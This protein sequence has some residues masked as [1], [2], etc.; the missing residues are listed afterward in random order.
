[1]NVPTLFACDKNFGFRKLRREDVPLLSELKAETWKNTHTGTIVNAD[2]QDRWFDS[3]QT[4][5]NQPDKL[6]LTLVQRKGKEKDVVG[7]YKIANVD[8]VSRCA[9]VGWDLV[10]DYRGMGIGK[11]IVRGGASF[12]FNFLNLRRLT[13]EILVS[14]V[15]SQNCAAAANFVI[16]GLKREAVYVRKEYDRNNVTPASGGEYAHSQVWGL[17]RSEINI[18]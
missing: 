14:N 5:H 8:W 12:C 2:D 7:F 11:V 15:A 6:F 3:M 1:M 16:E 9:D 10:P 17:L 18:G 4:D 13:A